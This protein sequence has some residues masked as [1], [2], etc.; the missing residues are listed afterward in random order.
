MSNAIRDGIS[1]T[2]GAL[3]GEK[4]SFFVK[5]GLATCETIKSKRITALLTEMC[6]NGSADVPC[7]L[8]NGYTLTN[9]KITGGALVGYG[10]EIKRIRKPHSKIYTDALTK[11][12]Q[13]KYED[14]VD[15]FL[16]AEK[17]NELDVTGRYYLG[18]SYRVLENCKL[19][20]PV[21]T[22]IWSMKQANNIWAD[23]EEFSR[24]GIFLLSRCHAKSGSAAEAIFYLNNFLLD[25]KKYRQEIQ[26]SMTHKDFGWIH[27]SKEYI[28]YK[29]VAEKK[30][31]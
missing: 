7:L 17:A 6:C 1:T 14:A 25:P 29:A 8:N 31:K 13:K 23:E 16:Q 15:L 2:K 10:A 12:S 11:Y 30:I 22:K 26:Q 4:S 21:L 20:I 27:N 9:I 24:R 3:Q 19:A 28:E 18:F 5:A